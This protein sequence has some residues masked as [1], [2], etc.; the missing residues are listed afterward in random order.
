MY[1]YTIVGT[2]YTSGS[3]SP[4]PPCEGTH[5]SVQALLET[6]NWDDEIEENIA[7][8]GPCKYKLG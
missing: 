1:L 3:K 7:Q 6:E 8:N 5:V 4:E 2:V